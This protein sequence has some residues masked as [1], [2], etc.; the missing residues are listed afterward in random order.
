MRFPREVAKSWL[1]KA[2]LET[3]SFD[4]FVSL[5]FGFNAIYNEFFFGNERQA[6]GDLVYSN[7]YTLNSQKLVKIF[8]HHSVSFFKTR[9]IRDCRGIGKD[10][11]EYAAIIG[12]TYYSPNRRLKALLMILYQVRCNL[13]HGNKIY[14]RDSDRQVISN[15]AAALLIILQAYINL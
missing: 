14:D 2:E 7:Q 9:I 11:S 12:N 1:S 5:W 6:I 15:A 10:T 3:D 13:F 8:N 4:C